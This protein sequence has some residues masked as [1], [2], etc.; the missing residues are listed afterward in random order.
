MSDERVNT[1]DVLKAMSAENQDI[2]MAPLANISNLRKV[3]GGTLVTIG[4]EGDVVE[5]IG[6]EGRFVGGLILA[7][8]DQ[9]RATEERLRREKAE[10]S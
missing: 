4:V 9:Y 7:D 6:I 10:R 1:F 2:R 5:A 8:K 3:K